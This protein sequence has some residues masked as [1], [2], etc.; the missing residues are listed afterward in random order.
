MV[1]GEKLVATKAEKLEKLARETAK[2]AVAGSDGY[3]RL[4]DLA[5]CLR[6]YL[7]EYGESGARSVEEKRRR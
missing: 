5:A 6:K 4:M 1:E 7:G 2:R 3:F